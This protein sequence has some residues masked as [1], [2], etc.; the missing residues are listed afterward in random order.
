MK[1]SAVVELQDGAVRQDCDARDR[2]LIVTHSRR[3]RAVPPP[4]GWSDDR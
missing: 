4:T 1:A 3:R 2:L